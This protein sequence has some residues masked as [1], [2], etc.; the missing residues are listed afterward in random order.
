MRIRGWSGLSTIFFL[1]ALGGCG[2]SDQQSGAGGSGGAAGGGGSG[3]TDPLV[4]VPPVALVADK[5]ADCPGNF[6][7]TIA[8]GQSDGYDIAGQTRSFYL[9]LPPDS[10]GG[11]RPL[12]VV[13]N[14][15]GETG[16]EIFD[17][18]D[19]SDF[20]NAGFVVLAPDSIGN[21]T[22]W[23]VWDGLRLPEEESLENKDLEYF[24]SIVM[25][26]AAHQSVDKFRI[27]VSGHS[28]GGIFT[29]RVLQSRSDLLAG[30]IPASGVFDY[31]APDPAPALDSMAVVVTWG[32]DN[33]EWGGNSG[34]GVSVPKFNFVEQ[35]ALASQ[36]YEAAPG[37][38]QVYC[39]GNDVGHAWLSPA[40]AWMIDYLLAHP[41]GLATSSS[42]QFVAPVD[43]TF[44]CSPDAATFE[45]AGSVSC[46]ASATA[47]CQAY[48]QM[49]GDGAVENATI[50]PVLG[51]QLDILGFSGTGH[52][53][54]GGCITKCEADA[55]D[56]SDT[57]TLGC[58]QTQS[59]TIQFGGGIPGAKPFI[60]TVN[61]CCEGQT[62]SGVCQTLCGAI[63]QN[64]AAA[65]LFPSCAAF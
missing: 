53:E 58:F 61:Q 60:D 21:G 13:F 36:H 24:D 29:N 2:G 20:V 14:G 23:P 18:T 7:A 22:L 41:K 46:G 16:K 1:L 28:A 34:G 57:T 48:C 40:N 4:L 45:S 56:P 19:M 10:F 27:Y 62:S 33:D 44:T 55:T 11:P 30:G 54:C 35:A 42:W 51:P 39:R 15:T 6:Q 37:L 17:R 38:D 64:S 12:M 47:G 63:S 3:S 8:A 52:L 49:L 9:A 31:T 59:T 43:P 32:G 65:A 50:E 5:A 25:C 26:L